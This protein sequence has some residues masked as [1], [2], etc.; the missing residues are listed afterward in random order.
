MQKKIILLS[1]QKIKKN[2]LRA[3]FK[4][5]H[6]CSTIDAGKFSMDPKLSALAL[7]LTFANTDC[8]NICRPDRHCHRRRN[9]LHHHYH[10]EN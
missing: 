1:Y 5:R 6:F 9:I 4:F 8:Y 2:I 10:R 7:D 3:N